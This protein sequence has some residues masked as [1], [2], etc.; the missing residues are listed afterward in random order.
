M[1]VLGRMATTGI[2]TIVLLGGGAVTPALAQSGSTIRAMTWNVNTRTFAAEHW[3]RVI[4]NQKPDIIALQEIC[5]REAED[6]KDILADKYDLEYELVLG[7]VRTYT[8]FNWQDPSDNVGLLG[9]SCS[10]W[11]VGSGAYGQALLTRLD[12]VDASSKN[13]SLPVRTGEGEDAEPRGYMA[14]TV[15]DADG[16]EIRVFN[17]HLSVKGQSRL[18]QTRIIADDARQFPVAIVAGDLNTRREEPEFAPLLDGFQDVG[19]TTPTSGNK[20]N[21]PNSDADGVKIDYLLLRGLSTIGG[22]ETYWT[23]S[24]DHRPLIANIH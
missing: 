12:V 18:D 10:G 20:F 2:A 9:G 15:R 23:A 5:V 3:A 11:R 24:S 22:P 17:T 13:V 4:G 14:V 6:L 19:P 1:R 8:D 21:M 16:R 7:S